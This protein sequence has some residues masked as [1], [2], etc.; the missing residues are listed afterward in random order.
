MELIQVGKNTYY[1]KNNTNIG[2]YLVSH[3]E[4]YLIDT[5]ND[6]DAG[7]KILKIIDEHGWVIKGIINTHSNADHIGGNEVIQKRSGCDVLSYGREQSFI[8]YPDFESTLLY[9]GF[10]F[11][12]LRNKFLM[13][14][15]SAVKDI[16][17]NLPEGLSYFSLKGHFVD[18]I[19]IKTS[20]DVYFLGDALFSLETISKYG[21]FFLYDVKSFLETLDYLKTLHGTLFIPSHVSALT[22]LDSLILENRK[23][24][25]EIAQLIVSFCKEERS[26]EEILCFVFQHY[27]LAMNL[28][29]Y[30][31]V[32]STIR[33]YLSYLCDEKKLVYEFQDFKMY[34]KAIR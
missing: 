22:C 11:S 13:A 25:L 8:E 33:S 10:P 1:I 28:N 26:F 15:P 34:W 9:G 24:V 21:V 27:H 17:E 6:R 32:G 12:D 16:E 31:L 29:Q 5:G 3:F 14:K 18:M 4:V 30:V 20:D 2:I 7:K 23:K 19:G